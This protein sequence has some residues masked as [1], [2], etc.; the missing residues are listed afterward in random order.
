MATYEPTFSPAEAASISGVSVAT[1]RKWRQQSVIDPRAEAGWTRWSAKDVAGL[2]VLRRLSDLVGPS[3]AAQLMGTASGRGLGEI[4]WSYA[5]LLPLPGN[6]FAETVEEIGRFAGS[7]GENRFMLAARPEVFL[8]GTP[9]PVVIMDL[10]EMAR[11]FRDLTGPLQVKADSAPG[12]HWQ[13]A[14][15]AEQSDA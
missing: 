9:K 5:M 8:K 12:P 3:R 4:V 14:D 7:D 10:A 13:L 6:V 15:W 2:Y 11:A 1:Q